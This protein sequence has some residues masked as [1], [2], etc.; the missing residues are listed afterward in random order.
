MGKR[1][2]LLVALIFGLCTLFSKASTQ[3]QI[4]EAPQLLCVKGDTLNWNLPNVNCGAFLGYEIYASTQAEGPFNLLALITNPTST[5]FVHTNSMG[6]WF[7]YMRSDYDCPGWTSSSSDTLNNLP[8]LAPQVKRTT[9]QDNA[10]LLEWTPS[11]SKQVNAHIIYRATGQ[12]TIP[13]DTVDLPQTSYLDTGADVHNKEEFYYVLAL[14]PCGNTS[15]FEQL[16]KTIFVAGN[17]DP[18][19]RTISLDWSEYIGFSKP[20]EK[21]EMNVWENGIQTLALD[22]TEDLGLGSTLP[23]IEQGIE[24][25]LIV[26]ATEEESGE[27]A[28]SNEICLMGEA[29]VPLKQFNYTD[30]S[31][32][33]DNSSLLV[34]WRFNEDFEYQD[35][36]ANVGYSLPLSPISEITLVNPLNNPGEASATLPIANKEQRPIHGYIASLDVCDRYLTQDTLTSLYLEVKEGQD[37]NN[38][39]QW[40]TPL[41]PQAQL[42]QYD[43]Y[44]ENENRILQVVALDQN[45]FLHSVGELEGSEEGFCYRIIAH[46]E[47]REDNQ[48]K[49]YTWSSNRVCLK[50]ESLI[51]MANAIRPGGNNATIRPLIKF[52][53][54]VETY[55]FTV[56]DRQGSVL[57]STQDMNQSWGGTNGQGNPL[58]PGVYPYWVQVTLQDGRKLSK[59]GTIALIR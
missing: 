58:S 11:P 23:D 20:I 10:V 17:Q 46:W 31:T 51:F 42:I 55:Q 5:Q 53:E 49:K 44:F 1:N 16:Q 19:L 56:F 9:V 35:F 43:V 39:L 45:S 18:C 50:R 8:P 25:C 22:I 34:S 37:G 29:K 7:Y 36:Y 24:Y 21:Y 15:G 48:P 3:A 52:N 4:I 27:R 40:N 41:W 14:D 32:A 2:H 54:S 33:P 57:F 28:Q 26:V 13:I 47:I 59:K 38:L 6:L 12:G 30:F